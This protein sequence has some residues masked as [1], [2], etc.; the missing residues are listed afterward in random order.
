MKIMI[1][2]GS[3]LIASLF[4]SSCSPLQA[5]GVNLTDTPTTIPS[6]T[7]TQASTPTPT[8]TAMPTSTEPPTLAPVSIPNTGLD[9]PCNQAA[10]IDDVTIPDG[11]NISPGSVFTKTWQLENT[12]SCAWTPAY[13]VVFDHGALLGAPTSFNMPGDVNPGQAVDISV[14]LTAPYEQGIYEGFW[15]L[16][17]PNG[18]LFGV[19]AS[20]ADFYEEFAVGNFTP[21]F[22]VRHVDMSVDNS[23]VTA[24]CPPGYSFT[25]TAEIYTN[26]G[27]DVSYRWE[28]SDGTRSNEHTLHFGN[29]RHKS[30][31]AIFTAD[32]TDVYS[33]LIH[34]LGPNERV[35]DKIYF[36]LTCTPVSPTSTPVPP[37]NTPIPPTNTPVPPTMTPVSP[38]PTAISPSST[39]VPPTRTPRPTHT[40][41]DP[42]SSQKH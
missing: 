26:G 42:H 22:D 20:S 31:S 15:K 8:L 40:P 5:P 1:I 41:D 17:D 36:S 4:L 27:G 39:P 13:R 9:I 10:F 38:T 3:V 24:A 37:N 29:A 35:T 6:P 11:T 33:A 30:V 19:G 16:K 7:Q 32:Q 18:N 34:V 25:I 23:S 28:F 14:N 2:L 21:N 12:G